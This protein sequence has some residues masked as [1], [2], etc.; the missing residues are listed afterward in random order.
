MG[1]RSRQIE[2]EVRRILSSGSSPFVRV[3]FSAIAR[4]IG[5]RQSTVSRVA[6]AMERDGLIT[7]KRPGWYH[8]L[9]MSPPDPDHITPLVLKQQQLLDER[10]A[11][12]ETMLAALAPSLGLPSSSSLAPIPSPH[13]EF[14]GPP[15]SEVAAPEETQQPSRRTRHT[16]QAPI[17]KI[18]EMY[19]EI[20]PGLPAPRGVS[21][22]NKRLIRARWDEYRKAGGFA[23]HQKEGTD[24]ESAGLAFFREFFETVGRSP[25][26]TGEKTDFKASLPWLMG[27][28]NFGKVLDGAFPPAKQNIVPLMPR[29]SE[30][31]S[32][33]DPRRSDLRQLEEKLRA[34]LGTLENIER[35]MSTVSAKARLGLEEQADKIRQQAVI[36]ES[37]VRELRRDL[38]L[39]LPPSPRAAKP[40][41]NEA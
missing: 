8:K 22:S 16:T 41:G 14:I 6:L 37:L 17:E 35:N 34:Q 31:K 32:K 7:R 30:N 24:E 38:G 23:P 20:L 28:V 13:P 39:P 15:S 11:R 36:T 33:E 4:K 40:L 5:V 19:K 12:I 29:A 2:H 26:L 21:E 1:V 3:N 27:P 18:I 9:E 10:L 25:F